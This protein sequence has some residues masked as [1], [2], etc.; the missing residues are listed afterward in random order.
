MVKKSKSNSPQHS[1][2]IAIVAIVAVVA[3]VILVM[4][5]MQTSTLVEGMTMEEGQA[6]EAEFEQLS[7]EELDQVIEVL[8]N[9]EGALAGEAK[10][11]SRY[12]KNYALK[13][14]YQVKFNKPPKYLSKVELPKADCCSDLSWLK[15]IITKNIWECPE[16]KITLSPGFSCDSGVDC[17]DEC[18]G[19]LIASDNQPTCKMA[20]S[21]PWIAD[22]SNEHNCKP[23]I[24][25]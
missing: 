1:H 16:R 17:I 14:A 5:S 21:G 8:E 23:V 4:N 18:N 24:K 20:W 25:I 11:Y 13:K 22:G 10:G 6:L 2:Y 3:V 12:K 15:K 9:E 7:D 19:Q